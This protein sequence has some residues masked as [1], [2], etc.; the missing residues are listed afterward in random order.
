MR[1]A[2]F[3]D[4]LTEGIPGVSFLE[5]LE[6]MLPEDTL[7]NCGKGGDTVISLYC[8]IGRRRLQ[9]PVDVAVL[10]VG[11]NDVLAKL[12]LGHAMLKR[13]TRQPRARDLAEFSDYYHRT[14]ESLCRRAGR[15]LAVS[16]L[17]VGEDLAS[18]WNRELECLC[19]AIASV[20]ASFDAV[21][22]VDLR[23]FLSER[24]LKERASDYLPKSVA[25]I[26]RDAFFLRTSAQVDTV[27]SRRGLRVTLDGV[28]L[29]SEG[30]HGVATELR[31]TIETLRP[32]VEPLSGRQ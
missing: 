14:L 28:H 3:G 1:I 23:A 22:Y 26:A 8:R 9:G 16:P 32:S 10:W 20:S 30:A 7:L 17:S 19:E 27:A 4:S 6:A 15:V 24:L 2:C 13:I 31:R 25:S 29:N 18:P 11:V 5:A 21:Q 12:S